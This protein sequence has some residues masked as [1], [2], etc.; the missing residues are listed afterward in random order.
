MTAAHTARVTTPSVMCGLWQRMRVLPTQGMYR[1]RGVWG[2]S[3]ELKGKAGTR[4]VCLSVCL[5][6]GLS[7]A[8]VV[9]LSSC[10][11]GSPQE[12]VPAAPWLSS[13][14]AEFW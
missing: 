2:R 5:G 9:G 12:S 11:V 13:G 8:H 1:C 3:G 7:G 14:G 6:Q 10:A 4:S